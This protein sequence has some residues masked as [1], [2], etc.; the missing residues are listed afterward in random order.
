MLRKLGSYGAFLQALAYLTLMILYMAI[1]PSEGFKEEMATDPN[2]MLAFGLA[3]V[4]LLKLQFLVDVGFAMGLTVLTLALFR[5]FRGRHIDTALLILGTGI[6]SSVLFL[7]AGI[8]GIVTIDQVVQLSNGQV[9]Q[10]L[11]AISGVQGGLEVAAVFASGWSMLFVAYA[12]I[13]SKVWKNWMNACGL[14]GAAASILMMP[15]YVIAPSM[16]GISMMLGVLG[17]VF[18]A[19]IGFSLSTKAAQQAFELE[20]TAAR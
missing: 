1:Y 19:G 18:N 3:H 13:Q 20:P 6:I 11:I 4:P 10:S 5:R 16:M 12:G 2:Q 9:T 15:L 7:V 8:V 17:M 14:I